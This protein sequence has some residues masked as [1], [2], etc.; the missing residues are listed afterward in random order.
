VDHAA[1]LIY[2]CLVT[3]AHTVR[4]TSPKASWAVL[5]LV[6]RA[7]A[8]TYP[9]MATSFGTRRPAFAAADE[10]PAPART[11]MTAIAVPG[12]RR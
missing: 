5:H 11:M 7:T 1:N 8:S 2:E 4:P 6:L 10:A 3:E 12:R 9:A